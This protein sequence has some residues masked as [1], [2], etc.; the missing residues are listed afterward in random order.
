MTHRAEQV[1]TAI[2]ALITGLATTGANVYRAF[3]QVLLV[4]ALVLK[5]SADA[6][7]NVEYAEYNRALDITIEINIRKSASAETTL[8]AIRAELFYALMV[9]Q[10]LGLAFVTK[11][12]PVSDDEPTQKDLER[13]IVSQSCRYRVY[14]RHSTKTAEG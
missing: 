6:V 13:P 9:D 7:D 12:Q 5:Q 2:D 14:Y 11:T 10:T 3:D 1:I 8:N 4:P